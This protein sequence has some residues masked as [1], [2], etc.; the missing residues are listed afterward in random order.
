MRWVILGIVVLVV[1]PFGYLVLPD[2][3]RYLRLRAM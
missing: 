2:V 1:L 3:L